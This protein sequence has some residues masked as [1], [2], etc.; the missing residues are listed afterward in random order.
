MGYECSSIL[1]I[2]FMSYIF[3]R[4]HRPRW[5]AVGALSTAMYGLSLAFLHV[6]YG[7]GDD[8]YALTHEYGGFLNGSDINDLSWMENQKTLCRVNCKYF[9]F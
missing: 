7:P 6:I 8:A 2:P 9:K 5:I 3:S 1:I 4:K